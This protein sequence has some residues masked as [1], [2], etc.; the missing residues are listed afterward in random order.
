MKTIE[1][2]DE[3]LKNIAGVLDYLLDSEKKH[4]EEYCG[5]F[6]NFECDNDY[7]FILQKEFYNKPE[8]EHIY[9]MTRR[10]QDALNLSL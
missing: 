3:D 9:A 7:D 4:Y 1:L 5:D 6:L 8:I 2:T 10:V